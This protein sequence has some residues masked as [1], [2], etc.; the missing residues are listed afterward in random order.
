[1]IAKAPSEQKRALRATR[2]AAKSREEPARAVQL[3]SDEYLARCRQLSPD[4]IVRFLEEFRH[5]FA[6]AK[7][8]RDDAAR[9]QKRRDG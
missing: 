9:R 7:T 1:M 8:A 3:F 4:D 6:A 2:F 5:N